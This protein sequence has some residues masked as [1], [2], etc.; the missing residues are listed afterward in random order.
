MSDALTIERRG[1]VT[2]LHLDDG[3]ANALSFEL[4]AAIRAAVSEAEHDETVGAVV[5]HGREGR[6]SGGFDLGVMFGGDFEQ[7]IGLVSAGGE[8]VRHLWGS[9]VPV[10]AACTGSAVAGGALTLLGCDVRVGADVP[11]KIGLNEVAIKM[12]LPDWALT[13]ALERLSKRHVHRAT[14]NARLTGAHDAVDVGFL[15]EV[16]PADQV[17]DRAVAIATELAETLDPA[18]YRGTVAK[19]RGELLARMETQI[20]ADRAAASRAA[21]VDTPPGRN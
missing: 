9:N 13:I 7:I 12:V 19:V 21:Q 4:V 20:A 2:V 14:A 10:V 6:F 18:S 16:V 17:L 11:C 5:V 15:D 8:M 3:K 1:P